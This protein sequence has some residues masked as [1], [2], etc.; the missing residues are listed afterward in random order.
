MATKSNEGIPLAVQKYAEAMGLKL[1]DPRV[2]KYALG[3]RGRKA[4]DEIIEGPKRS[5]PVWAV[6]VEDELEQTESKLK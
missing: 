2:V 3:M 4:D 6:P 5:R 1:D